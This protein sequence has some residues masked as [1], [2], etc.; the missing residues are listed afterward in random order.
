MLSTASTRIFAVTLLA[1]FVPGV[2]ANCWFDSDGVKTC[3]GLSNAARIVLGIV[4]FLFLA[5]MILSFSVYCRR[6]NERRVNLARIQQTQR[7]S[8]AAYGSPYGSAGGPAPQYPP[9]A[10]DGLNHPYTYD[11]T[12]GFAPPSV[13][14]PQ[15]YPPPP[16][17]PPI[18]SQ[19]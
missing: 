4:L 11:P 15:Y 14:P 10:H 5:A 16:G 1:G 7:G 9:P 3:N 17:A 13:P 19:K 18:T 8:G 2:K 12:T 6:R